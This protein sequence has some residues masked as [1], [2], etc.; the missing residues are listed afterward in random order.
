MERRFFLLTLL[1]FFTVS[2]AVAQPWQNSIKLEDERSGLSV[3]EN[4]SASIR[5][6]GH[7]ERAGGAH[8]IAVDGYG[9]FRALPVDA[10]GGQ[11]KAVLGRPGGGCAAGGR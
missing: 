11:A 7:G 9:P 3:H 5:I 4:V 8:R 6:G 10:V 1:L 2:C